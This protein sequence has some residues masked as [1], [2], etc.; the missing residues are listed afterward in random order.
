MVAWYWLIIMFFVGVAFTVLTEDY[1]DWYDIAG[2][3]AMVILFIPIAFYKIFLRLVIHPV[4][5]VRFERMMKEW[6]EEDTSKCFHLIGNLYFWVDPNAK[7][8]WNKIFFLR[9]SDN[10]IDK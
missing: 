6:V 5:A 1:L 8:F 3:L 7:K 10:C 9:V 4:P 2:N